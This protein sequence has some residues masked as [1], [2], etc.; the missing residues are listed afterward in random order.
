MWG[1]AA[2]RAP[3]SRDG[4][5]AHAHIRSTPPHDELADRRPADRARLTLAPVHKKAVLKAPAGAVEVAE[6]V[7]RGAAG[8]DGRLR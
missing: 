8:V 3:N 5:A 6:I 4:L 7:D 1:L 2:L